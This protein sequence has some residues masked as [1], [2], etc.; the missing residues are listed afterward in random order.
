MFHRK[1]V[2]VDAVGPH[3]VGVVGGTALA[4]GGTGASVRMRVTALAKSAAAGLDGRFASASQPE[5]LAVGIR[6]GKSFS[7]PDHE[8]GIMWR[9]P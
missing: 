3:L 8:L 1:F 7:C 2:R 6:N 4:I 5:S 9:R